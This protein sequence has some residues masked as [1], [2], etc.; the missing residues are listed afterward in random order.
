MALLRLRLKRAVLAASVGF[1]VLCVVAVMWVSWFTAGPTVHLVNDT[2]LELEEVIIT[3]RGGGRIV[4]ALYPGATWRG[5]VS[6]TGDTSVTVSYK[7]PSGEEVT[8][9]GGYLTTAMLRTSLL[10]VTV[11]GAGDVSF[12]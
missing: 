2:R 1:L 9:T 11:S 6:V 10:R 8:R 4:G 12:Q 3:Y 5:Q 7:L